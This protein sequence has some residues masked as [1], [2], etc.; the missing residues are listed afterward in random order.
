MQLRRCHEMNGP[1]YPAKSLAFLNAMCIFTSGKSYFKLALSFSINSPVSILIYV[2]RG[3]MTC[4][5]AW[6]IQ[7]PVSWSHSPLSRYVN[8]FRI[9]HLPCHCPKVFFKQ[10]SKT[11]SRYRSN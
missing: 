7:T 9:D 3:A 5:N 8:V 10:L 1:T 6:L 4:S 2:P 11:R